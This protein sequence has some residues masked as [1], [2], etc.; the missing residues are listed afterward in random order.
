MFFSTSGACGAVHGVVFPCK[1]KIAPGRTHMLQA[2]K[3]WVRPRPRCTGRHLMWL[4]LRNCKIAHGRTRCCPGD[5]QYYAQF[6]LYLHKTGWL[7][8][9]NAPGRNH[10]LQACKMWVRPGAIL[11]FL[12]N[13]HMKCLPVQQGRCDF[14]LAKTRSHLVASKSCRPATCGCD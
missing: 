3:M 13:D 12:R 14:A 8:H 1:N 4:F 10:I 7:C 6:I 11:Q 2:C 5:T 9:K